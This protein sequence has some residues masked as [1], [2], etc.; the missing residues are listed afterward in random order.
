MQLQTDLEIVTA[1]GYSRVCLFDLE[2]IR[3]Y[4]DPGYVPLLKAYANR[5]LDITVYVQKVEANQETLDLVWAIG[6]SR[7]ILYE[8]DLLNLFQAAGVKTDWWSGV[9][10]SYNHLKRPQYLGWPDLR[11]EQMRQELADWAMQMPPI[12][13]GLSLDYIRWNKVGDGRTAGQVTD[14]VQKI[15]HN[16]D[17]AG[18]GSLSAAV[19]PYLGA[20]PNYGGALSVGQAWDEW[21]DDGLLDWVYPMAYDSEHLGSYIKEWAG[22]D[23]SKIVPCLSV[24]NFQSG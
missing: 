22:Y 14:L 20:S 24:I 18:Q 13:G 8:V 23:T 1:A 10:Y 4:P 19:Y 15:R 12:T 2:A 7:V 17:A 21:L 9:A 16:W 11:G 6:A 3:D 5:D